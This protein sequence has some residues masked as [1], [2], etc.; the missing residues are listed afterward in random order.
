[1]GE[2]GERYNRLRA[3]HPIRVVV[4]SELAPLLTADSLTHSLTQVSEWES[5]RVSDCVSERVRE[6]VSERVSE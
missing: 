4:V 5:E 1:M 6:C 2:G 3:L